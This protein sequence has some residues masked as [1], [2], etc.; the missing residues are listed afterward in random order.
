[1]VAAIAFKA[2]ATVSHVDTHF[3]LMASPLGLKVKGLIGSATSAFD[4]EG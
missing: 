2:G 3:D 1:V 4:D